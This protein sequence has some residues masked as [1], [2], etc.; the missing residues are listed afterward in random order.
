[1]LTKRIIAF[2]VLFCIC[3]IGIYTLNAQNQKFRIYSVEQGL[4]QS[5]V[6]CIV[7]DKQGFIWFGTQDGLNKYNGYEFKH[8]KN[9]PSNSAS[10]PD[11]FIQALFV[12][13]DGII[14]IGTYGGG[15]CSFNPITEKFNVFK[16]NPSDKNS[17]SNNKVMTICQD[18]TGDLWIGTLEGGV[19]RF[20]P[21]LKSFKRYISAVEGSNSIT[22]NQIR[23]VLCDSEQNIWIG[24]SG[25]GLCLYDRKSDKFIRFAKNTK[26]TV[27]G[28]KISAIYEDDKNNLYVCSSDEGITM[29]NLKNETSLHIFFGEKDNNSLSTDDVTSIVQDNNGIFW[30]GTFGNGLFQYDP[31]SKKISNY[32][33]DIVEAN[34]LSH[35]TILS[36]FKDNTGALWI[37]TIAGGVNYF[38]PDK[39]TFIHFGKSS[40]KNESLN[41]SAVMC[42]F[43]DGSDI[44]IGTY[45][46]GLNIYNTITGKYSYILKGNTQKDLTSNIVRCIYKDSKENVWLGTY[47]GGL[48]QYNTRTQTVKKFSFLNAS[49]PAWND[50]WCIQ[51]QKDG[52]LW[53][54]TW[55]GLIDFDPQTGKSIYYNHNDAD[56][57]SLGS[58]RIISL[59]IDEKG[60]IW[61]GTN[62]S[63]LDCFDPI[64]KSFIHFRNDKQ[65]KFSLSNDRV[66]SIYID[67]SCIWIGTDGGGL[68]KLDLAKN[69]FVH[70]TSGNGLPNNVV[71]G[72]LKDK[73]GFLWLST[74]YGLCHF[75]PHHDTA[76]K[77]Y[78]IK[79]GLQSNEF[80]QGAF[81]YGKSGMMYFGGINGFN[82]FNPD[83]MQP[84]KNIPPVYITSIKL[85]G[86]EIIS[87]TSITYRKHIDLNY[88]DNF[89]SFEFAALNYTIPENNCY[90]VKMEGFDKDYVKL[91]NRKFISYTN[92]DPGTYVF[93]VK[94]SNNDGIWNETGASLVIKIK[95]PF[96]RTIWFQILEVLCL[97]GL[98]FLFITIRT[99]KLKSDKKNLE[100]KVVIRTAEIQQ[101]K[102]EIQ[103]QRD[104]IEAQ[105]DMAALQRDKIGNQNKVI[106]DSI[107]YAKLI[108]EAILPTTEIFNNI[109]PDSFIFFRPKAIVSGD[110]YWISSPEENIAIVSSVDCTGHGVPGA[111][112]SMIGYNMINQAINILKL[113]HPNEVLNYMNCEIHNF[114]HRN[115]KEYSIYD[116]MDLALCKINTKEMKMEFSGAHNPLII[117]RNNELL[118]YK[119]DK[120]SI[121]QRANSVFKSYTNNEILLKKG[122]CLYLF[123]DGFHDQFDSTNVKKF[124]L[125]RF[126]QELLAIHDLTMEDQKEKLILT[127]D[128]WKGKNEQIDDVLVMGIKI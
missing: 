121:G 81:F 47:N 20:N 29:L 36:V 66:R 42:I 128:T 21:K 35:N 41:E 15:L 104:E 14:W 57:N 4:S 49:S 96:W 30:I 6:N 115:S 31:S 83:I 12:D 5:T 34:S 32:T 53:L 48:N 19:N 86:N 107:H 7:Q 89:I 37:G 94:A 101:Q 117:I 65:N 84:N 24:T 114:L 52:H 13:K 110:F 22:I 119:P 108:Q 8:Y 100:E 93:R 74:N 76:I 105:R 123:S 44:F 78:D 126:K 27:W 91:Y 60:R 120:F 43:E 55:G 39:R 63:G 116:G 118:M 127:F 112:M 90:Q 46:G 18:N 33:N 80:N 103:N 58:D 87:D 97:I 11:N 28:K 50:I 124:T 92:L 106:T 70:F 16:N 25:D 111:L 82:A 102:E 1:M 2:F 75:D 95:P 88:N 45:G 61:V 38:V 62:G 17:L 67:N 109:F 26:F 10:I 79:N 40:R 54:G 51:E 3:S 56:S 64:D 71:Y 9:N 98:V 125:S 99:R 68:N 72:I 113:Q 77:N 69:Q 85:R 23:A 122:D 73:K 59:K